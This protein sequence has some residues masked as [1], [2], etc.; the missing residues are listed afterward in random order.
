MAKVQNLFPTPIMLFEYEGEYPVES[1]FVNTL[2]LIDQ[3]SHN[4]ASYN[5]QSSDHFLLECPELSNL[6]YWIEKQVGIFNSECLKYD[7][8]LKITQSWINKSARGESHEMHDHPNSIVSGV[9]YFTTTKN[10]PPI[11]FFRESPTHIKLNITSYNT[12]NNNV[13]SYVPNPGELLLFPSYLKHGVPV[14]FSNDERVSLSFNTWST[15]PIGDPNFLTY[16][17]GKNE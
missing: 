6:K 8:E 13:F 11:Q 3:I 4:K 12:F 7:A 15:K 17:G 10:T 2:D 9:F 5:R 1:D 16:N 14:N